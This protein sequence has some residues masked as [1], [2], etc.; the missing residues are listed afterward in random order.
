MCLVGDWQRNFEPVVRVY[1]PAGRPDRT[2]TQ[3]VQNYAAKHR[4]STRQNI[5]ESL[6]VIS[7]KHS[8]LIPDDGSHKILK[9]VG[10]IFNFLIFC[11]LN[12]QTT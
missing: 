5:C 9:H 11:L 10:V 1:G 3:Q 12:F 7:V 4:P 2:R 6:Q 8:S